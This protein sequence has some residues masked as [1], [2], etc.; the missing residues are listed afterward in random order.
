M[1]RRRR[2]DVASRAARLRSCFRSAPGARESPGPF[3]FM[4]SVEFSLELSPESTSKDSRKLFNPRLLSQTRTDVS[5][6]FSRSR[7]RPAAGRRMFAE[8]F[9]GVKRKKSGTSCFR[10]FSASYRFR[11]QKNS[12]RTAMR[13]IEHRSSNPPAS[14]VLHRNQGKECTGARGPVPGWTGGRRGGG[15]HAAPD[16]ESSPAVRKNER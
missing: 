2:R 12:P 14:R 9:N 5:V 6:Q 8:R 1:G 16:R 4:P 10:P 13:G 7:R 15:D 11:S 3:G